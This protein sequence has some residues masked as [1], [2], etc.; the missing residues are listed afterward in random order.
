MERDK[1]LDFGRYR[2]RRALQRHRALVD[3]KAVEFRAVERCEAFEP[4]ERPARVTL[5]V[6]AFDRERSLENAG[7]AALARLCRP[8]MGSAVGAEETLRDAAVVSD[9]D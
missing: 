4:V 9:T 6:I 8:R 1:S 2:D 3:W 5:P 7:A